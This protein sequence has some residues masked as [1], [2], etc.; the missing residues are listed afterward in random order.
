MVVVQ[1]TLSTRDKQPR[2]FRNNIYPRTGAA[3]WHRIDCGPAMEE[4]CPSKRC[5]V[6]RDVDAASIGSVESNACIISNQQR[7]RPM[8]PAEPKRVGRARRLH[9]PSRNDESIAQRVP[10]HR[11]CGGTRSDSGCRELVRLNTRW[12]WR[13]GWRR[14][15]ARGRCGRCRPRRE[16]RR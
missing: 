9:S 3:A 6:V 10:V 8:S 13:R 12:N 15:R 11:K 5:R 1:E 16:R 7:N 4:V 14:G 2:V